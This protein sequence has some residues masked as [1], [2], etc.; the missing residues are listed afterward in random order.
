MMDSAIRYQFPDPTASD[1]DGLVAVGGNLSIECLL[2]AYKNG[3]F[4]WFNPGD[5]ILWWSPEPRMVIYPNQLHI[6][7][8]VKRAI[9]NHS[10]TFSFDQDFEQVIINCS[11]PRKNQKTEH[12]T[13]IT[14]D[15]IEAYIQLHKAGY[16]HSIECWLDSR[17]CGGVYGVALGTV[18]FGESMFSNVS[19]SSKLA[20]ITLIKQ[21]EVWNYDLLDCQLPSDLVERLGASYIS[22][23]KFTKMIKVLTQQAQPENWSKS[24]PVKLK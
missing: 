6:P 13:W 7:K 10:F 14:S 3:I 15:M 20:L 11:A 21:L 4:P 12:G 18:F 8:S 23:K 2:S 24:E 1:K 17:L 5:P 9:K 22:R 19:E 16:A